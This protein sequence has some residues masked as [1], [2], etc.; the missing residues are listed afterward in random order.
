MNHRKPLRPLRATSPKRGSELV[1]RLPLGER[2]D[3]LSSPRRGAVT[4]V[5]EGFGT[6]SP[7]RGTSPERGSKGPSAPLVGELSSEARL[8]G[9][10]PYP[11]C[12]VLPL[13]GEASR[14]LGSPERGSKSALPYFLSLF[15]FKISIKTSLG[16]STVPIWR[17]RFLPSFCFSRSFFFRVMSPP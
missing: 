11:P 1:P 8:R 13:R 12:G 5:T 4:Q 6:L 9:L 15:V 10:E 16:T 14:P 3:P 2:T 17:M 7:L